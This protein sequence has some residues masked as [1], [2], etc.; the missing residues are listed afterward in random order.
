MDFHAAGRT[1]RAY[2]GQRGRTAVNCNPLAEG[3]PGCATHVSARIDL[4][5]AVCWRRQ[6][7]RG[8]GRTGDVPPVA[9]A[10]DPETG[11]P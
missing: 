7:Q 1:A 11:R 4:G 5:L 9:V 6:L 10:A 2:S 8:P 3:A